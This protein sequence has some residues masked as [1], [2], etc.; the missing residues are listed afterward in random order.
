MAMIKRRKKM[1]SKMIRWEGTIGKSI[2]ENELKKLKKMCRQDVLDYL[3]KILDVRYGEGTEMYA[4]ELYDYSRYSDERLHKHMANLIA[5]M[6]GSKLGTEKAMLQ[7]A[8]RY[9]GRQNGMAY[10]SYR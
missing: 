3:K 5:D 9:N 8:N 6:K 2:F 1:K 10:K 4:L 7:N